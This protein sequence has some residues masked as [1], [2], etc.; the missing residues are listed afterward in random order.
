MKNR[1]ALDQLN[2][3]VHIDQVDKNLKEQFFC[4]SCGEEL[5][6]KKGRIKIHHFAHKH[7]LQCNNET[8]LH[9]LGKL[10]FLKEYRTSIELN[11][12]FYLEYETSKICTSCSNL[13]VNCNFEGFNMFDL[14]KR[15]DKISLEKAYKGF[16]ADILLESSQYQDKILVEIAVTH[17]CETD[18][19]N[20]GLRILEIELQEE[21]DLDFLN[22]RILSR[23]Q[24]N[25]GFYNFKKFI[26][27]KAFR[28]KESCDM[29]FTIFSVLKNGKAVKRDTNMYSITNDLKTRRFLHYKV[30]HRDR[31]YFN[32]VKEASD[33]GIKISNCYACKFSTENNRYNRRYPLFCKFHKSEIPNSNI[34][35]TCGKFWRKKA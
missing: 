33:A 6:P 18:K 16:V 32:L 25:L 28:E 26:V 5:I 9:K 8:Y 21:R 13:E 15:F 20:S 4:C 10:K 31:S 27:K 30:L 2:N 23:K 3:L 7:Q 19:I 22:N 14:T 17:K 12:P 34:A 1:Y 24:Q 29:P 11:Q 35:E